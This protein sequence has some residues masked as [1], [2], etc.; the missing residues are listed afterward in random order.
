MHFLKLYVSKETGNILILMIL[1]LVIRETKEMIESKI[2]LLIICYFKQ[3]MLHFGSPH[4]R[5]P[6]VYPIAS[7]T[8]SR[9]RGDYLGNT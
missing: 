1:I 8:R 5:Q 4:Q 2:N 6:F 9:C 7:I 3:L